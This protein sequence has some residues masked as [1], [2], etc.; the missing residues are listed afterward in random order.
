MNDSN[1]K[2]PRINRMTGMT[3]VAGMTGK[4][5]RKSDRKAYNA[6][7]GDAWLD[8]TRSYTVKK[9]RVFHIPSPV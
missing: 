4:T 8:L 5:E 7:R 2:N 6:R 9:V 1:G 3:V